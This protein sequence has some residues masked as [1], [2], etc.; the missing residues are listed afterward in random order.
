MDSVL[1]GMVAFGEEVVEDGKARGMLEIW[2]VVERE[3]D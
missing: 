2:R 1:L 3:G